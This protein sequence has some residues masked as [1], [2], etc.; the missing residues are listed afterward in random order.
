MASGDL[1]RAVRLGD[2]VTGQH[3]LTLEGHQTQINALAFSPDGITLAGGDHA[4]IV[5][6]RHAGP[7]PERP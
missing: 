3:L 5:K 2:P 1:G 7:I 4:G 6:L